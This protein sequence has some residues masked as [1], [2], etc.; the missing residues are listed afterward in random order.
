MSCDSDFELDVSQVFIS[1]TLIQHNILNQ[2]WHS[3]V[4]TFKLVAEH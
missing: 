4:E 1:Q 2:L 3:D